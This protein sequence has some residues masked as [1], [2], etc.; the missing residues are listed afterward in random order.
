MT[1]PNNSTNSQWRI[2][3]PDES[4]TAAMAEDIASMV[5][6]GDLLTL[7]GDLGAGKTAFAR[8]LIRH[9]TGRPQED[10]PSPTFTIIQHYD[11]T[12]FPIIHADLFRIADPSE[13]EEIGWDETGD[14]SLVIV[15][16]PERAGDTLADDRLSVTFNI[17]ANDTREAT[18]E[19][20]GSFAPKLSR[21]RAIKEFLTQAGWQKAER[22]FMLG[23]ASSRAYERLRQHGKTAVLMISPKRPD[24]P[25]IR[26]GKP[27]S[28]IAKLAESVHAFVAVGNGLRQAGLN[29]PEIYAQDVD[30]GLLLIEDFG[31]AGVIDDNGPVAERY[32]AAIDVLV[33]L[34]GQ[35]LPAQLP[36]SATHTHT[37][38]PFDREAFL[39]EA[40]L[41]LDWYA[42]QFRG[43][44]ISATARAEF[45]NV[46]SA[47]HAALAGETTW[48]LRDYHSPNL[49]W[50]SER[51]NTDRIGIIDFQD[52]LIGHPAYDVASLAQDARLD[53][54]ED[55]ELKLIT[56]YIRSR[57]SLNADF[58]AASFGAAYATLGAQRAT[59]ILGI[60]TRLD[61]RD[62]KPVYLKHIPRVEKYLLRNL[63]HPALSDVRAWYEKILPS[64]FHTASH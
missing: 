41:L 33:K 26:W 46:W 22:T 42:P 4:A 58:D 60:F 45:V 39:I 25:P 52:A 6:A 11:G 32:A 47:A 44:A 5:G 57:R 10:V 64:L 38:P 21:M 53:I 56:Y 54:P 59:K 9:L 30:H 62:R 24:G 23:D 7:S 61:K 2:A 19:G 50:L 16:W 3:L 43:I 12:K 27:Y 49:M 48:M 40:E 18:I 14:E 8:Y 34:H 20:F 1:Q 15:E 13:L 51:Q 37:I 28:A 31:H 17:L 36:V 29:A 63:A 55:L 35:P